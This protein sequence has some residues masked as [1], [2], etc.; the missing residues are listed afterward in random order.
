MKVVRSCWRG[1]LDA[2]RKHPG[3]SL[4]IAALALAGLGWGGYYLSRQMVADRYMRQARQAVDVGDFPAALAA[5]EECRRVWPRDPEIRLWLARAHWTNGKHAEATE[6]L[7][8]CKDVGGDTPQL[9]LEAQML[10]ASA[11]DLNQVEAA[12]RKQLEAQHPEKRYIR[13]AL[14]RG[15]LVRFR[16]EDAERLASAWIDESPGHWQPWLLRGI[17]RTLLSQEL[18]STAHEQAKADFTRVLEL[19]PDDSLA[20][21]L[22]GNAQVMSGQ[23][24]QAL[25]H[26]EQ[27]HQLKP[28]DPAGVAVLGR[29]L[30]SLGRAED[31]RRFLDEWLI[32]H[33]GTADVFLVR[34]EVAMDL[35][36][37][38]EALRFFQQAQA[39]AP[40]HE[41][42]DF[43]LARALRA[44]GRTEE[45]NAH[46]E[47]WRVRNQLQERLKE[48]E[49]LAPGQPQNVA[50]R[51][52]AGTIA[53]KL[54]N[55]PVGLRWLAAVLQ[56]DPRHKATHQVLA[57]HFK[58]KGNLE[59]AGF[60][61]QL[62]EHGSR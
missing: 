2:A 53:L 33:S 48:L 32:T 10:A 28:D 47:K 13:E 56:I 1:L 12:L 5:L 16:T 30:R 46:E 3:W 21:F 7:R 27:Y 25:P 18:L 58:Q 6:Y 51:Y 50:I 62:A 41:K 29:C 55:E 52:E 31:A 4:V 44:L 45:A 23:F 35:G 36:K 9:A 43:Q 42:I 17:A 39:R 61:R 24:Q 54:G 60:H 20:R 37:A 14:I 26:L 49:Q 22:L 34:G 11:G 38:A 8:E 40:A 19:K 57:D 15:Y 59:A